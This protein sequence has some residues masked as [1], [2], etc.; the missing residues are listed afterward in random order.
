M[1]WAFE[2]LAESDLMQFLWGLERVDPFLVVNKKLGL[3]VFTLF[4]AIH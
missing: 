1:V 2:R 3:L 4:A